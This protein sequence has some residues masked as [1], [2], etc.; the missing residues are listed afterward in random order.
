M[1]TITYRAARGASIDDA[2]LGLVSLWA[3]IKISHRDKPIEISVESYDVAKQVL[4]GSVCDANGNLTG[5]E[6]S[7]HIDDI[8]SIEV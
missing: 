5:P 1:T 4:Y 3:T 6:W 8:L 2:M 7:A